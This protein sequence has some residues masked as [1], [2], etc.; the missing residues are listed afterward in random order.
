ME[1]ITEDLI[2]D[3]IMESA[4]GKVDY[5]AFEALFPFNPD[6]FLSSIIYGF[7][8]GTPIE[9]IVGRIATQV[10]MTGNTVDQQSL[11][12]FI[13]DNTPLIAE[14]VKAKQV[15]LRMLDD[16]DELEDIYKVVAGMLGL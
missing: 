2:F 6:N 7:A 13:E 5:A 8:L 15:V 16:G 3:T 14:E 9:V 4:R 10:N 1:Q 11:M 12:I